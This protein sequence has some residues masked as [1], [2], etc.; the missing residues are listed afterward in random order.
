MRNYQKNKIFLLLLCIVGL[1]VL[2]RNN[3]EFKREIVINDG[4][5]SIS[6]EL[7]SS[8]VEDLYKKLVILDNDVFNDDL[9]KNLFFDF[10]EKEKMLSS[11]EKLYIAFNK[12]YIDKSF[13]VMKNDDIENLNIDVNTIKSSVK[14]IFDTEFNPLEVNYK[15]SF[16]CGIIDYLFTGEE[17]QIRF[18]SCEYRES[19]IKNKLV[20]AFKNG[21]YIFLRVKAYNANKKDENYEIVN[22]NH[23][24]LGE[25]SEEELENVFENYQVDEY[26]FSFILRSDDYYLEKI[27]KI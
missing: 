18:K 25:I 17:Y 2:F 8:I 15:S 11:D 26:E 14:K 10:K 4:N 5:S 12:L 7:Q 1:I 19:H 16:K 9:Y 27:R 21:D 24:V 13:N 23:E 22:F 6:L 3:I 20:G